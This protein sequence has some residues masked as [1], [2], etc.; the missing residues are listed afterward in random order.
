[1]EKAL[2]I[3]SLVTNIALFFIAI[4]M[5]KA[6]INI[7]RS[8]TNRVK[9]MT[10]KFISLVKTHSYR[11]ERF[12]TELKIPKHECEPLFRYAYR[13]HP[14]DRLEFKSLPNW[15][16]RLIIQEHAKGIAANIKLNSE[17][18]QAQVYASAESYDLTVYTEIY[19]SLM[20]P[21]DHVEFFANGLKDQYPNI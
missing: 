14:Y 12:Q 21:P 7:A 13:H 10:E 17:M 19:Y 1:M 3:V 4:T 15:I 5:A 6:M 11:I 2:L 18:I 9:S 20:S 8:R 16:Q